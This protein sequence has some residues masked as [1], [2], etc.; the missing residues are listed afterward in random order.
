LVS[1]VVHIDPQAVDVETVEAVVVVSWASLASLAIQGDGSSSSSTTTTTTT[2]SSSTSSSSTTTSSSSS[3]ST[4]S[5]GHQ[6][7]AA[8]I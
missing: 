2:T 7:Y 3:S 8:V 1:S 5:T 4:S 6:P